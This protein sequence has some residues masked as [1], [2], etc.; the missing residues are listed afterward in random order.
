[1][2]IVKG[3]LLLAVFIGCVYTGRI[4]SDQY[5]KRV[6]ELK[7]ISGIGESIYDKI[8]NYFMV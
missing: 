8:K 5:K 4:L 3:M 7:E 6:E 2:I 1:M